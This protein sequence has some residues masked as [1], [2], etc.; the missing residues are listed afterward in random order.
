MIVWEG[1]KIKKASRSEMPFSAEAK[2]LF[3]LGGVDLPG[4]FAF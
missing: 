1:I 4:K 3:G 2:I